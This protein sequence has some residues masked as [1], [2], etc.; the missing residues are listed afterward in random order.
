MCFFAKT[1]I[2]PSIANF[3]T[4]QIVMFRKNA[5]IPTASSSFDRT[6]HASRF[7]LHVF[8]FC[9]LST[10]Y[11]LLNTSPTFAQTATDD[12]AAY[13]NSRYAANDWN[14][15]V[16]T[17]IEAF[18][19]EKYNEAQETLYKALNKGC[20]SPIVLFMLALINEYNESYYSSL[21]YYKMAQKGCSKAN[22]DHRYCENWDENYGR[23]LYNSGKKEEALPLLTKAAKKTKSYWLLKMLGM[24]AYEK[25]DSLNAVSYFERAVRVNDPD[26]NTSELVYVYTLLG[27]LFLYK[28]ET[29]GALR[30][31]QKALELNPN[32]DEA[33]HYM[34]QIQKT[35]EQQKMLKM[36][37]EMKE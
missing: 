4:Q 30:Y 20:E 2:A 32:A 35:Y 1:A 22:Q 13:H 12:Y 27:K 37:E 15:L 6:S 5:R 34:T 23:A 29:D 8:L 10:A 31:F 36:I 25:G 17:G 33:R 19:A 11:C 7:T 18:H 3:R 24:M 16:K 9:L 26:V 28:G 14:D 21:E